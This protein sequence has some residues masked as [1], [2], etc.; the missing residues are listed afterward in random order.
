MAIKRAGKA[1]PARC[2]HFSQNPLIVFA[3]SRAFTSAASA[4]SS[5]LLQ[6]LLLSLFLL[7]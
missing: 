5:S 1:R 7:R 2:L 6:G 4:F 3:M